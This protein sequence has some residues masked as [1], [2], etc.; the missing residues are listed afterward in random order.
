MSAV[1]DTN[2][3]DVGYDYFFLVNLIVNGPVGSWKQCVY[4][5]D[6]KG[7]ESNEICVNTVVTN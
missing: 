4:V 3:L 7:N 5:V 2:S 6:S 1:L